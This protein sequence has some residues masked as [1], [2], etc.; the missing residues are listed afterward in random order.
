M[1]ADQT[2]EGAVRSVPVTCAATERSSESHSF[3]EAETATIGAD[4]SLAQE[5][6]KAD[7]STETDRQTLHQAAKGAAEMLFPL[8]MGKN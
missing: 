1:S 8:E 5:L 7:I 3:M 2:F 4:G 6:R